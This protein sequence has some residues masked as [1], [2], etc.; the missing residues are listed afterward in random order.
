MKRILI[1]IIN[2]VELVS[3][4]LL[5]TDQR[6]R[7]CALE[8]LESALISSDPIDLVKRK[9]YTKDN[10]LLIDSL[11][12]D[13]DQFNRII[14]VG[15][16]KA[17]GAMASA[18]EDIFGDRI[19]KGLINVQ[20]GIRERFDT[21]L[22]GLNEARHPVPDEGGLLGSRKILNILDDVSKNDLVISIISGGGSA[23]LPLPAGDLEL[24]DMQD[25]TQNLLKCGATIDEVNMV[26]KHL[27]AIKGGRLAKHT[28]PAT[29]ICLIIS[30]VVGDPISSIASGPTVP[31]PS[32][33]SDAYKVLKRYDVWD[34]IPEVVK[35]HINKGLTGEIPESPKPDD[36]YFKNVN[37]IIL[38]SNRIA[39]K[40]ASEKAAKLGLTPYILTSYIEGEARHVG[41]VIAS[42]ARETTSEECFFK[43]PTAILVGGETTVTVR[44]DG[45]GGR[46]QEL[47][48]SAS[49]KIKE[50]KGIVILSAGTDGLDGPTDAAGA[51]IDGST[52][53]RAQERDMNPTDYLDNNDSY[54]FF[55]NIGDLVLTGPTGT[56]VN[57]IMIIVAI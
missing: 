50:Q 57:D 8:I 16:G 6:A 44:G 25:V 47:A 39:L 42:L 18:V 15:A 51:I 46:N 1:R 36:P 35:S 21:K 31:D 56:N 29:M 48:L 2:S 40:A 38:G 19:S 17:S 12:F 22:I 28:Y 43:K 33:Y 20:K 30:D 23:L 34:R 27:S 41:T 37:N 24:S 55:K 4:T 49:M 11:K 54:N 9:L 7:Q 5:E 52:V 10:I 3:N 26:R 32:T 53:Q 14:V 13:L 45:R